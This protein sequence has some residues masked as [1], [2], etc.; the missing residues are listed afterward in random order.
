MFQAVEPL[1]DVITSLS[2]TD[3]EVWI[4]QELRDSIKQQELWKQFQE[5]LCD[6]FTIKCIPQESQ[7]PIF[8]SPDILLLQLKK[9]SM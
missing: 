1:V 7:H 2:G 8:S 9:K 6:D 4:V 5:K 3:T